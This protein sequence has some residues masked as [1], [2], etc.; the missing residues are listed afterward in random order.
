MTDVC[1]EVIFQS[2]RMLQQALVYIER[3]WGLEKRTH[4]G[5]KA[6]VIRVCDNIW[7][8][9]KPF[10]F[11]T[12]VFTNIE[13]VLHAQR[14]ALLSYFFRRFFKIG[15]SILMMFL[16]SANQQMTELPTADAALRKQL[17][18]CNLQMVF[19]E[20]KAWLQRYARDTTRPL[21]RRSHRLMINFFIVKPIELFFEDTCDHLEHAL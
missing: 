17:G 18:N 12:E 14:H 10:D 2:R 15:K 5:L 21:L 7:R 6:G 3:A 8:S 16:V 4:Q 1:C 11:K 20:Q 19:G 9:I 13:Q